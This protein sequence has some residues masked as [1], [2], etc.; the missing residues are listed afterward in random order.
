MASPVADPYPGYRLRGRA[1][2]MTGVSLQA[3]YPNTRGEHHPGD[4]PTRYW[5]VHLA[6]LLM[7]LSSPGLMSL[8]HAYEAGGSALER[9]WCATRTCR[10]VEGLQATSP[11]VAG[12]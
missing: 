11:V 6:R 7:R 12:S 5:A 9:S 10:I 8:G 1:C 4:P 3:T 2:L